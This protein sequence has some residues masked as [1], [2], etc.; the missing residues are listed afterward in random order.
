M[1]A[2]YHVHTKFSDDSVYP[3]E[4]VVKDAIELGLDEICFTDH[5]DYGIKADWDSGEPI[6]YR[7]GEPIAN[8]DYPRYVEQIRMLQ[9][10]YGN[11][12]DVWNR[13]RYINV[14]RRWCW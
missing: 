1:L 2:D 3:M 13:S 12:I 7:N 4:D 5:V 9:N 6:T 11:R 14:D 10:L 8:V